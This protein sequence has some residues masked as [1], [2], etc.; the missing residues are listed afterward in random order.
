M[1]ATTKR[2]IHIRWMIRKDLGRVLEIEDENSQLAS[3]VGKWE[4]QDFLA[5]MG[6]KI[7]MV[8][9]YQ[10]EVIGFFVYSLQPDKIHVYN[11]SVGKEHENQGVGSL[12]IDVL[13][14][15]LRSRELEID[16]REYNLHAQL[17]LK[18][19][20]FLVAEVIPGWYEQPRQEDAYRF[21]YTV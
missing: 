12:L 2:Q 9:E 1:L 11:M 20:G 4:E 14:S 7:G 10:E 17:F 19:R 18:K 5:S 8:A 13:K 6:D 15:K 21:R 16:I 3:P